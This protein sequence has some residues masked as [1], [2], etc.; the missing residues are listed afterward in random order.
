MEERWGTF[1]VDDHNHTEKLIEDVLLYDRL[2]FPVPPD[3][4][5]KKR[6]RSEGWQPDVQEE[7]LA[8]LGD[9]AIRVPWDRF[10]RDQFADRMAAVRAISDDSETTIP[11]STAFQMTRRI[12][13]QDD[14]LTLPPGVTS[15]TPVA[16]Y[17]SVGALRENHLFDQDRTDRETL[18]VCMRYRLAQPA[19]A[20]DPQKSLAKA[21]ALSNDDDFQEK[22][23]ALYRW[24]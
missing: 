16:A 24:E 13:A 21:I 8:D 15:V 18:A 19:F 20:R 11:N 6:W 4:G 10:R 3:E 5:E 17:H 1:S 14:S 12:L 7:R 22:R 2:V 23:R 9:R